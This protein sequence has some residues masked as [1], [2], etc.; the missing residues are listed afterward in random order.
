[1]MNLILK[2]NLKNLVFPLA[3]SQLIH[4]VRIDNDPFAQIVHSPTFLAIQL[5]QASKANLGL[6]SSRV[7]RLPETKKI[8][9]FK[10]F[11][12]AQILEPYL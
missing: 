7:Q 5:S 6:I 10:Y 11:Q 4:G 1:M 8:A 3:F 12:L 9:L 2:T